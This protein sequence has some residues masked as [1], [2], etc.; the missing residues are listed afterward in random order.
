[1]ELVSSESY[2]LKTP[3]LIV[4]GGLSFVFLGEVP[5]AEWLLVDDGS[6]NSTG[7]LP[8]L[9]SGLAIRHGIRYSSLSLCIYIYIYIYIYTYTYTYIHIYIYIYIYILYIYIYI[10]GYIYIY[11]Y[12]YIYTCTHIYSEFRDLLSGLAT[13]HGIR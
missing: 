11:I 10:Y 13:R 3:R 5:S 7:E 12:I 1:L 6:T 4:V 8:D 9:L 2:K